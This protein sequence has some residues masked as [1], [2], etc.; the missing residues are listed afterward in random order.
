MSKRSEAVTDSREWAE[1][2]ERAR[3]WGYT[4]IEQ[5]L[6]ANRVTRRH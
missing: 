4:Y 5:V 3:R 2:L 1:A 6:Y